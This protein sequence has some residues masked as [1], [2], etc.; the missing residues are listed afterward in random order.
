MGDAVLHRLSKTVEFAKEEES[1]GN[2]AKAFDTW[3]FVI[4][5][6][7]EFLHSNVPKADRDKKKVGEI[8]HEYIM[9]ARMLKEYMQQLEVA[10]SPE[11]G[12]KL[13]VVSTG[14]SHTE[15]PEQMEARLKVL[16]QDPLMHVTMDDIIG[17]SDTKQRIQ[18]AVV[19]P[20]A[21]HYF[22]RTSTHRK[23]PAGVLLFGAPGVAKTSMAHA[24]ATEAQKVCQDNNIPCYFFS[25]SP[26]VFSSAWQGV[27]VKLV[28]AFFNMI[29]KNT[30][31][32][33][34]ID[35]LE[36][37][38]SSREGASENSIQMKTVL[39][40]EMI[41]NHP[42]NDKIFFIGATNL[43]W[44]LDMSFARRFEKSFY[45]AM[46]TEEERLDIIHL[47]LDKIR[48]SIMP[49][50]QA[51]IAT[52]TQGFT[53]ADLNRLLKEANQM[54]IRKIKAAEYFT[55][56]VKLEIQCKKKW[57]CQLWHPCIES[58]SGAVQCRF[59][60]IKLQDICEPHVSMYDFQSALKTVEKTVDPESLYKYVE[61]G[62]KLQLNI[63]EPL[64][65]KPRQE[66]AQHSSYKKK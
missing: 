55:K 9:H 43:P 23:P 8:C 58:V 51:F 22:Y 42:K 25:V 11:K 66:P 16:T 29:R 3:R 60:H 62:K 34:F 31:A 61:F 5:E 4:S 47:M 59:T 35:E 65:K 46:P 52:E 33:V 26:T 44:M 24:A 40:T 54:P 20:I 57:E 13:A 14:D 41:P 53:G 1:D 7:L 37:L 45:I 21:N 63:K 64:A 17:L 12:A 27:P 19:D 2:I 28:S 39:L 50:E 56:K 32:I 38:F 15:T 30:P 48:H 10:I 49:S 6:L 18:E 36:N